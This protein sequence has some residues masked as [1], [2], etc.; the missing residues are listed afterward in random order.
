MSTGHAATQLSLFDKPPLASTQGRR[1]LIRDEQPPPLPE[2]PPVVVNK[3]RPTLAELVSHKH[4]VQAWIDGLKHDGRM[5]IQPWK[6]QSEAIVETCEYLRLGKQRVLINLPTGMG[7]AV[8][9]ALLAK[10]VAEAGGR[11][12]MITHMKEL[13][14]QGLVQKGELVGLDTAVEKGEHYAMRTIEDAASSF[15]NPRDI[16][17]VVA[18]VDSL[19]TKRLARWSRDYFDLIIFDEG[20]HLIGAT[21][22]QG[23]FQPNK[24]YQHIADYFRVPAVLM[25]AT[26]RRLSNFIDAIS[27]SVLLPQAIEQE[28]LAKLTFRRAKQEVDLR[29]LSPKSG[30]FRP[31]DLDA[32]ITPAIDRLARAI[33]EQM[34]SRRTMVFCPL[35]HSA[36]LMAAALTKHGK[37]AAAVWGDDPERDMKEQAFRSGRHQFIVVCSLWTEGADFTFCNGIVLCRPTMSIDLLAQIIGRGTRRS[38]DTGKTDCLVLDFQWQTSN[39]A[40]LARPIDLMLMPDASEGAKQY[41]QSLLD[42]GGDLL[43]AAVAAENMAAEAAVKAAEEKAAKRAAKEAAKQRRKLHLG[44]LQKGPSGIDF[45]AVDPFG[46]HTA[47]GILGLKPPIELE[48]RRLLPTEPQIARLRKWKFTEGEIATMSRAE[49]SHAIGRTKERLAAGLA[50][51]AQLLYMRKLGVSRGEALTLTFEQA[52]ARIDQ[53]RNG[54]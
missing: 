7:K 17:T 27:Y 1:T 49:A 48:L 21:K 15:V 41:A 13:I 11:T 33:I 46:K 14:W 38:P 22:R 20:H 45:D 37:R 39:L 32:R 6:Y 5:R 43:T 26:A 25:T 18:S 44:P 30:D 36:R 10:R 51:N 8:I 19:H 40:K 4:D 50:T 24:K 9:G 2:P 34:G 52:S 28:W 23:Q 3:V 42:D 16:R 47:S 54:R 31:E 29:G 35:V 12:L 53:L